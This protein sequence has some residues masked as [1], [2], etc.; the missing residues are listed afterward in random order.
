MGLRES[1]SK[2]GLLGFWKNKFLNVYIPYFIVELLL[3]G[4]GEDFNILS[5]LLLR[6][7]VSYFWLILNFCYL[8]IGYFSFYIQEHGIGMITIFY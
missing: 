6:P 8:I 5:L 1:F 2:K 3:L 4:E 7:S